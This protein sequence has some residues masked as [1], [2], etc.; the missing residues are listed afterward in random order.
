MPH[1]S[2]AEHANSLLPLH[3]KKSQRASNRLVACGRLS[4]FKSSIPT[5]SAHVYCGVL[6][7]GTSTQDT[8]TGA[9]GVASEGRP[10]DA[11]PAGLWKGVGELTGTALS[12]AEGVGEAGLPGMTG[13]GLV[14]G[15]VPEGEVGLAPVGAG[16]AGGDGGVTLGVPAVDAGGSA[17]GSCC[18]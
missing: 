17:W 9:A 5:C 10:G 15:V 2:C 14:P 7:G 11:T 13:V 12:V 1:V 4:S 16:V 8:A 3:L 6:G 18:W